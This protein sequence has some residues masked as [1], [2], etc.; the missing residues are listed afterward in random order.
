[1]AKEVIHT[2]AAQP[3]SPYFSQGIRAGN[4]L[5]LSGFIAVDPVTD[6][7]VSGTIEEEA[8]LAL[9]NLRA[10]VEAAGATLAEVMK[11]TVYLTDMR[12]FDAFNAVYLR[13]FPSDPPARTTVEVSGHS[14]GVRL[15]IEAIAVL[16][17]A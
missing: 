8:T 6:R 12:D 4:L 9:N 7:V 11:T 3:P 13:Y 5:F 1:M 2:R 16:P 17:D 15:K 10:V 14:R